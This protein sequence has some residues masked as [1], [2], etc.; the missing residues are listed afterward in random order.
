[1]R[2][3]VVAVG[4]ELTSGQRV[5]TNSHWI[6][7]QLALLGVSVE[8]HVTVG[9]DLDA[10]VEVLQGACC[11]ADFV[12]VSGGLGPTAD[13][14]TRQ[15]LSRLLDR[16][17]IQD[18]RVLDHIRELFARRGRVMPERNVIQSHFPEGTRPIP[19]P[20]GTAPGIEAVIT[21]PDQSDSVLFALPGVPAEMTEMW[22]L[23]VVPAIEDRLGAQRRVIRVREV[24]CFG[25]G[26]SEVESRLPDL[27]RR[28]QDPLVGI[29]A[30]QATITLRITAEGATDAECQAK[31]EP[32]I[33]TIYRCLGPLVFGEG[34]TELQDA[35]IALLA[36]SA[37]T[38]A[39]I[40]WG[41]AGLVASWLG[42]VADSE[43]LY[44]GGVVVR[45]EG[46]LVDWMGIVPETPTGLEVQPAE[47]VTQMAQGV[48]ARFDTDYG[49][50]IGPFPPIE[51]NNH[52]SASVFVAVAG[53]EQAVCEQFGFAAHP[54]IQ[55]ERTAKQALNLARLSLLDHRI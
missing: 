26:E 48:R 20:H 36:D 2:A 46:V 5:D 47:L 40:E 8:Q 17:L 19:N 50:A 16:P 13:D 21:R 12:V 39:T 38:L 22:R 53:R 51:R 23:S 11:R 3:E 30:S 35:L 33:T 7:Q 42:G 37:R 27:V 44:R 25:A 55:R 18:D 49:L 1:M 6:S 4:D 34:A 54:A 52:V 15:A 32:T 29:T 10:M 41:T 24:R 31:I 43:A 28:G 9:D 45:D 14:L